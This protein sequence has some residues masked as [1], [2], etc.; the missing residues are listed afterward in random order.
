MGSYPP[1]SAFAQSL[2]SLLLSIL[3][4]PRMTGQ[5]VQIFTVKNKRAKQHLDPVE[6]PEGTYPRI[7]SDEL[8][9]K[10]MD[11]AATNSALATRNSRTPERYLLRAGF[12]HCAYCG[13]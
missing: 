9:E 10:V 4:D 7:L 6:L 11:R 8:Y 12:A 5:N 2:S 1:A 3:P 13:Y